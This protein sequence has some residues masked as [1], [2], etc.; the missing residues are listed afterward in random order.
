MSVKWFT[1][2][3]VPPVA[4]RLQDETRPHWCDSY[5]DWFRSSKEIGVWDRVFLLAMPIQ[6][7]VN[8]VLVKTVIQSTVIHNRFVT[9]KGKGEK[10]Y[11]IFIMSHTLLKQ[12][13]HLQPR[14]AKKLHQSYCP[15]AHK[16]WRSTPQYCLVHSQ[17]CPINTDLILDILNI[18]QYEAE[19]SPK[20]Y[21]TLPQT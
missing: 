6:T 13:S 5:F 11:K 7:W 3:N 4:V 19:T 18:K 2:S 9:E 20:N 21:L 12:H 15:Q 17:M 10:E 14:D 1:T 8:F 16:W